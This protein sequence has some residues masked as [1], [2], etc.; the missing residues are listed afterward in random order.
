MMIEW[1]FIHVFHVC[2]LWCCVSIP[3]ASAGPCQVQANAI[4]P[5]FSS[6]GEAKQDQK[7]MEEQKE[8]VHSE[9]CSSFSWLLSLYNDILL[10]P[11]PDFSEYL[12][13]G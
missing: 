9:Y 10:W 1:F 11:T 7:Q 4:L 13:L 5:A 8:L 12:K 2:S 6:K 3:P